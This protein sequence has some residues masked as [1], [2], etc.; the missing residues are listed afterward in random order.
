MS[1]IFSAYNTNNKN[2]NKC[3]KS[4]SKFPI[5]ILIK[6]PIFIKVNN[7]N[8]RSKICGT[9]LNKHSWVTTI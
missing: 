7:N 8:N 6:F 2:M 3:N 9:N 5:M 4:N 1:H